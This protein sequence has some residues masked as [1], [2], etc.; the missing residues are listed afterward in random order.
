MAHVGRILILGGGIAGLSAAAALRVAGLHFE[1]FE[2]APELRE[3]GAGVGLWSNA[4]ESLDQLGVGDEVRRRTRPLRIAAGANPQGRT[5]SLFKLDD[6]GPDFATAA[7]FVVL[8]PALLAE[9]AR[10]LPRETVHTGFRAIRVEATDDRVRVHFDGGRVEEGNLLVGA[11]GLNSVARGH[12]VGQDAIRYSGQTC[13]RGVA[14]MSPPEPGVIR[15]V[16]GR[17]QRGSVCPVDEETV[18]W[19]VAH[20]SK[21]DRI[22]PQEARKAFLLERYRA[23]PFGLPEA[24][25]ATPGDAILQNDLVDRAPMGGYAQGRV[26]LTGDAAHP[27]T[28]NLGQGANMAVDDAIV[29]ARALRDESS[30]S[31]ALERYQQERLPRT[32]LVVQ[33]SWSFGR[34]CTWDSAL[35]VWLR[36]AMVGLTPERVMRNMLRWQILESVGRL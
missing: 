33:R 6:L 3:V 10:R 20:N 23:W 17:G 14:K 21:K 9:L 27:T 4:M 32:R 30:I 19:W 8:R 29:L 34:M 5:L 7:C 12:V 31:A 18:Y 25:A 28:P 24:I 22:V 2:Q 16:Q 13:F 15:E 36:E 26:V 11:D 1:V 35:G